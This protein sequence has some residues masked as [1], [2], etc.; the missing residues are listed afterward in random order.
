LQRQGA[1]E[2]RLIE[3]SGGVFEI[4]IDG[5]VVYSKR[6]TGRFPSDTELDALSPERDAAP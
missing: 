6:A 1:A 5:R 3:G 2:V 4:R